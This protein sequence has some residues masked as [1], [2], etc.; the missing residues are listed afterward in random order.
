MTLFGLEQIC[1]DCAPPR[2][3]NTQLFSKEQMR[4]SASVLKGS[5]QGRSII[6]QTL[7]KCQSDSLPRQ[8][9]NESSRQAQTPREWEVQRLR[10]GG[11]QSENC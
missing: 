2:D 10:E 4:G 5:A 1:Y 7:D 9:N 3:G 6:K 11:V 8:Q